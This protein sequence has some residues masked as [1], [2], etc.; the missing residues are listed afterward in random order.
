MPNTPSRPWLS[1]ELALVVL[2]PAIT[3]LAGAVM[4]HVAS[5]F[6]FTALGE[7]VVVSA[8]V[9]PSAGR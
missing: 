7:P 4:I 3:L 9:P 2:I 6:G 8:A 5:S 1:P